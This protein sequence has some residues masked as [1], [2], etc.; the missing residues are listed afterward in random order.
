MTGGRTRHPLRVAGT[1]SLLVATCLLTAAATGGADGEGDGGIPNFVR[2][3]DADDGASV[4]VPL[5]GVIA[6]EL[7]AVESGTG[8]QWFSASISQGQF[9]HL[10]GGYP[11]EPVSGTPGT[12]I[13]VV[14]A[15]ETGSTQIGAVQGQPFDMS[16]DSIQARVEHAVEVVPREPTGRPGW[17]SVHLTHYDDGATVPLEI[18]DRLLVTLPNP[19]SAQAWSPAS[20]ASEALAMPCPPAAT[21]DLAASSAYG[22]ADGAQFRTFSFEA[23]E[24]GRSEI[25]LQRGAQTGAGTTAPDAT[26]RVTVTVG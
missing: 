12:E 25:V 1:A 16:G 14:K 23:V 22:S 5:A 18:G 6:L 20:G 3:T 8:I 15:V 11:E 2:L 19:G 9:T 24:S 7:P 26:F 4:R 13:I 10:C 17:R 21:A